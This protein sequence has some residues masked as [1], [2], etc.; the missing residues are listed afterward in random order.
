M[1]GVEFL[2]QLDAHVPSTR[3]VIQEHLADQDG[4]LLLHLVMADVLRF[5]LVAFQRGDAPTANA[6]VAAVDE[7]LRT[8]DDALVNAVQV[9][10]VEITGPWDAKAQGFIPTWP[11]ALAAEAQRQS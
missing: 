1:T 4:E 6:V 10:F 9:S 3:A 11:E 2:D 8:G 7:A 5:A